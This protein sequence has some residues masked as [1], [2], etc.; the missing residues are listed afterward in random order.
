MDGH[1]PSECDRKDERREISEQEVLCHVRRE[2]PLLAP[3]G[4]RREDGE[5][6][7]RNADSK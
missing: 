1:R 5:E 6:E 3:G 2:R 7:Q 4:E